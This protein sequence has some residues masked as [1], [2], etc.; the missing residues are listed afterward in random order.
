VSSRDLGL[1]VGVRALAIERAALPRG[2]PFE[3]GGGT[4]KLVSE[5]WVIWA[6]RPDR[7]E[8]GTPAIVNIIAFAKALRLVQSSRDDGLLSSPT[9]R[10]PADAILHR[11]ALEPSTGR[12]L[13][14]QLKHTLIG[15][16]V[17]VPTQDGA[18]PFINLDNA[19]STPTFE[20]IWEAFRR[21]CRQ[22]QDAQREIIGEVKSV[23]A[24]ML[25]APLS[26]YDV[27]FTSNATEALNLAAE[28]FGGEPRDDGAEPVV[29]NTLL[30]HS[31]NDLPWRMIPGHSLVRL[32]VDREGFLDLTE[33]EAL[34]SGYNQKREHGNRRI[35]LVAVSGA[36]NVLGACNELAA[37]GQLAHRYG[38]RLLV[39]AAQL[40]AHRAI[41]M[42]R[43]GIDVLAFSAHKVYAPFGC[44]VLVAKKG[45]V[46][47]D[48]TELEVLRASGEEN[49]GGIAALGKA[50]VLLRRI[51]MG[52][53]EDE[54]RA[55]TA[56][57]LS[58]LARVPGLTVYGVKDPTSPR[59]AQ[60]LGVIVF[61]LKGASPGRVADALAQRSGIGVRHGCH[62]AHLIVK[63]ILDIGPFLE[64]FQRVIQ[65]LFPRLKL[66]GLV[67]VSLG[68]ENCPEDI[69]ALIDTLTCLA[70]KNRAG[71]SR[72][73][74]KQVQE[75]I[76]EMLE[77]SARRVYSRPLPAE[78]TL[79]SEPSS[80]GTARK[81]ATTRGTET[82]WRT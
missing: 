44:G 76:S 48:A 65:S 45:W 67:R 64:G 28:S 30:E 2:I 34:L 52:V 82:A 70:E 38:A 56:R 8:A 59:W 31:S 16:G 63:H 33:M 74:Q 51:G 43:W 73:S 41:D 58:G 32:S 11:D 71:V 20:P 26:E 24:E 40:V 35:T 42:E 27:V 46:R 5:D 10:L 3:T 69:D 36:S 15:R 29:L 54:E 25:G 13:L 61:S 23:C 80:A 55:L 47:F 77:A 62:C 1:S 14:D 50:L 19:A 17:S 68:L 6:D 22:P 53:I 21:T 79:A 7:L 57:A 60:R 4:T 49:A 9:G 18:R 37:I 75:Q 39:D 66:P 78:A 72:M 12:A 81:S